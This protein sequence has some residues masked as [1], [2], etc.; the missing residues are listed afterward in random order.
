MRPQGPYP[1]FQTVKQAPLTATQLGPAVDEAMELISRNNTLELERK[2]RELLAGSYGLHC[3]TLAIW[4]RCTF[5][6][7]DALMTWH[8]LLNQTVLMCRQQGFSPEDVLYGLY[9]S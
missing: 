8:P 5:R 2:L 4:L 7:S 9:E 3:M 6:M 1:T